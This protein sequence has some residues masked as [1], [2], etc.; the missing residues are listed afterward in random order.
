MKRLFGIL[1]LLF[2]FGC[3]AG[4]DYYSLVRQ[5]SER[6]P[7]GGFNFDYSTPPQS[8]TAVLPDVYGSGARIEG[9]EVIYVFTL[10]RCRNPIDRDANVVCYTER[11]TG[12]EV[13][14]FNYQ[15]ND[16]SVAFAFEEITYKGRTPVQLVIRSDGSAYLVAG[17][18]SSVW[19]L[20][21]WG[22]SQNE[23]QVRRERFVEQ[24]FELASRTE[25]Q[26]FR[27]NENI[28]QGISEAA[29]IG[30]AIAGGTPSNGVNSQTSTGSGPAGQCIR[31][32]VVS[33]SGSDGISGGTSGKITNTCNFIVN[34][35]T[36]GFEPAG[37]GLGLSA[38][39]VEEGFRVSNC[40]RL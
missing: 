19:V 33:F 40:R 5:A 17:T 18:T 35:Q 13:R 7:D 11:S 32:E 24:F 20:G 9:P 31:S 8:I 15:E 30:A 21:Y 39:Y 26:V 10:A 3:A 27:Q 14:M 16:I 29:I 28:R 37:R 22:R 36:Y 6:A 23:L 34:C 38:Y 12:N 1:S 25:G 2:V 4:E